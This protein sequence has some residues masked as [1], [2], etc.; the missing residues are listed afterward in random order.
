MRY[1]GRFIQVFA[2]GVTHGPKSLPQNDVAGLQQFKFL[3]RKLV[4]GVLIFLAGKK[5]A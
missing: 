1:F 3:L 5:A 4:G 2:N